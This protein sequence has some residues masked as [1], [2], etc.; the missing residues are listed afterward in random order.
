MSQDSLKQTIHSAMVNAMRAQDKI[1]LGILRLMLAAI[2]QQ[3]V[4]ERITLNDEQVLG[5]LDK[6]IRQRKESIKQFEM[7]NRLDLAQK[8]Q[9]EIEVIQ[10]FLPTQL[11]PAE[12]E[13]L[14]EET[15]HNLNATTLKDMGKVM[16]VLK[17]KIQGRADMGEVGNLIKTKLAS[18]P[19]E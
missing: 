16:A 12:I 5:L 19:A 1:R 17:P 2:K 9:F 10:S 4:D 7:G 18:K 11:T 3:E 13:L 8:E 15:I 14:L 6:M